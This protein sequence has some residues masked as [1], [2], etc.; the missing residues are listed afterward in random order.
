MAEG[1]REEQAP[2]VAESP[3]PVEETTAHRLANLLQEVQGLDVTQDLAAANSVL[4]QYQS[5]VRLRDVIAGAQRVQNMIGTISQ[6]FQAVLSEKADLESQISALKKEC[7][8]WTEARD[9]L[10]EETDVLNAGNEELQ[11]QNMRL[12]EQ[13]NRMRSTILAETEAEA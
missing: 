11:R 13:F 1:P 7:G 9:S 10:K 4:N 6:E 5:L 8:V 12:R 2:E 3:E